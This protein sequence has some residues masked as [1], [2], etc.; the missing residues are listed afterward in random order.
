[1]CLSLPGKI[2]S[3]EEDEL[4]PMAEVDFSGITKRVCLAFTPQAKIGAFVIVHVGFAI[5]IL[6]EE[7]AQKTLKL[8][9]E[10]FEIS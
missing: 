6:S 1:M 5:S 2:V 9:E 7:E 8:L 4:T 3:I 10:G